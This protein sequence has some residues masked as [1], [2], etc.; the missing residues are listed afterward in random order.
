[1]VM[2]RVLVLLCLVLMTSDLMCSSDEPVKSYT[3][4]G[5]TFEMVAVEGGSFI[6]GATAEQGRDARS[7][8]RPAHQVT[9]DDYYIGKTEVTQA[10]WQAVMG[11]NPSYF[12]GDDLPVESISLIDCQEFINRLNQ[13]T[14][15]SF[16]LPTEAEW[17]YAARGGKKSRGYKY[18]GS[19]SIDEVAW[20]DEEWGIGST[21]PVATKQPNELGIY[22]MSGN[23]YEYCLD[24]YYPY[25]ADNQV[26]PLVDIVW[27]SHYV[28][29]GG[30]WNIKAEYNRVS[31]RHYG[32]PNDRIWNIL[33]FK[34][35]HY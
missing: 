19:N 16:R 9:L 31:F 13:L 27:S 6:M 21:H 24:K 17:E 3:V 4:N 8:E 23:V 20:C 7:D 25:P 1:M 12:K 28:R 10:L 30:S 35:C 2:E 14:G 33:G 29:R 34:L 22:D 18:S 15:Q 26:N 32:A 11:D 5:V